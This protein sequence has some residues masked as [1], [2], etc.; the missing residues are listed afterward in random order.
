LNRRLIELVPGESARVV[1][2]DGGRATSRRI[3][4]MGLTPGA[5][6][7]VEKV[8]PLGDPI[9]VRVR[10]YSLVLRKSEASEVTVSGIE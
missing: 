7:R 3:L 9:E 4:A 8:A 5:T 6:V 10:G 1:D 2:V